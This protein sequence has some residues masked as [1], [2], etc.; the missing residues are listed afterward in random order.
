MSGFVYVTMTCI[1]V[2]EVVQTACHCFDKDYTYT[3]PSLY[4]IDAT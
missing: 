4:A 1:Y 3:L 2:N